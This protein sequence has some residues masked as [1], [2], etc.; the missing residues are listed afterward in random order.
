MP[1][2]SG[3]RE[4]Q[5][6]ASWTGTWTGTEKKLHSGTQL[7]FQDNVPL[8]PDMFPMEAQ[9]HLGGP[10]HQVQTLQCP[11]QRRFRAV[12]SMGSDVHEAEGI[13]S[14]GKNFEKLVGSQ[15]EHG[16]SSSGRGSWRTVTRRHS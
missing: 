14:D 11:P 12:F 3:H 10:G 7:Y 13:E 5:A 2:S 4:L 16:T 15:R 9:A 6:V 8:S 1:R